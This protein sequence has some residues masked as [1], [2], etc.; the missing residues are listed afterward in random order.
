[1]QRGKIVPVI[2]SSDAPVFTV[3]KP[4]LDKIP[5]PHLKIHSYTAPSRGAKEICVWR[6]TL[7]PN[8]PQRMGTMDHEEFFMV[9]SGVASI[10]LDGTEIELN[11][12]DGVFVP[13]NTPVGMGNLH[14]EPAELVECCPVGLQ[15]T[16]PG[17]EPFRP[18]WTE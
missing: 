11:P 15:V 5:T 9:L 18:T 12:G 6:I 4:G 8:L 14:D 10:T 17:M 1:M 7:A 13:P 16:F 2:R 3:N